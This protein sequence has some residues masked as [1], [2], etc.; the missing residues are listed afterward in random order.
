MECINVSLTLSPTRRITCCSTSASHFI[1]T[2]IFYTLNCRN[3]ASLCNCVSS[4][5]SKW[6]ERDFLSS[7]LFSGCISGDSIELYLLLSHSVVFVFILEKRDDVSSSRGKKVRFS[8][9]LLTAENVQN[10][11]IKLR[12][13]VCD[14]V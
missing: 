5:W 1:F 8:S 7:L 11:T 4:R 10:F 2:L 12:L 13:D 6:A 14:T 9:L 3:L